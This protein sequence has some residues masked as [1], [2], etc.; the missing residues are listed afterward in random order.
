MKIALTLLTLNEIDGVREYL[1]Q[2]KDLKALGVDEI[3]AVD[4]GSTDG[5]LDEYAK[6]GIRVLPLRSRGR[7]EAM[8]MASKNT[9]AEYLVFFSPD[10]NEDIHDIILFRKFFLEGYDLVIAS[11]MMKG[12]RNEEDGELLRFRK[13]ANNA[14]NY[15]ANLWF[16][17]QGDFISDSING[18]RGMRRT[19]IEEL[20]LDAIGFTIEYQMTIR[21]LVRGLK[22][23]EFPTI[24]GARIG[25]ETKAH[26]I[27]TGIRFLKCLWGEMMNKGRI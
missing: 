21:A 7:G 24:E 3:F 8:R 14:F 4:G 20:A 26:S 6:H 18:F 5:T 27:P 11:R 10:G 23:W 25:G 1:P 17:R 16:R 22:I 9:D 2:L 12:A 19:L 15:F 13:W